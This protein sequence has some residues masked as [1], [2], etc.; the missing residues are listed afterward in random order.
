MEEGLDVRVIPRS[1][2][3]EI[4][5]VRDGC[6]VVRLRAVPE[7]GRANEALRRLIAKRLGVRAGAVEL[8]RGGRSRQKT[9]RVAGLAPEEVRRRLLGGG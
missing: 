7:E 4:A 8:I 5:G 2:R 3:D 6:V 9:V 1:R